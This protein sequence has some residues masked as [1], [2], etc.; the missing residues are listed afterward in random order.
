MKRG[1]AYLLGSRTFFYTDNQVPRQEP[2]NTVATWQSRFQTI[3]WSYVHMERIFIAEATIQKQKINKR[4][5][6]WHRPVTSLEHYWGRRFFWEGPKFLKPCPLV[7]NYIEHI[8]P[9]G[10]KIFQEKF[11][12]P[13]PP[14]ARTCYDTTPILGTV[15][16]LAIVKN[17]VIFTWNTRTWPKA[18]VGNLFCN[19]D[20]FKTEYFSGTGLQKLQ[21]FN[22]EYLLQLM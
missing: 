13:A 21:M 18:G 9:G 15:V 12:P 2:N 22:N 4:H 16:L 5:L 11:R 7:L 14:Q 20:R 17:N 10:R 19:A 3:L 6:L 1:I 8:F